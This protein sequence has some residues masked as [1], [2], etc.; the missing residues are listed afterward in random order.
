MSDPPPAFESLV[1]SL[2]I[3]AAVC[4]RMASSFSEAILG[5]AAN[6][7]ASGGPTRA[8]MD[9]W[10]GASTR[11]LMADAVPLR[12]LGALHD[13]ALSGDD[14]ALATAYPSDG[15]SGDAEAAWAAA[16]NATAMSPERLARFMDHEPQTNEVRRSA[17]LLGGFLA[18]AA[19]TRLPIR[20]FEIGASAGLNQLWDRYAYR[21][22]EAGTWG[23]SGSPVEIPTD[24][25]GP[26]PALDAAV[27]VIE[28]AACDRKPVDLRD[29]T[30]RRRLRAYVWADQIDRLERL[31]A[32][33]A[34]ALE[35]GTA[36]D[37]EDAVDW[38]RRRVVVRPGAA[39]VLFHSVFWQY[40]PPESQ[41]ALAALIAEI[42]ATASADAPFAW[43]RMEPP[44]TDM[45][46]MELRLTLWPGG[47]DRRLG[48]VH[49][50]GVWVAW[51]D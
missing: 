32:A 4:G 34:M 13:L 7:V 25:R 51:G 18:I 20:L 29:P 6:D 11:D 38:T 1:Q 24:W 14:A 50:H 35:A 19:E 23:P 46:T 47:E 28:R 44:P 48:T 30:A 45:A 12:L 15:S 41:A 33:V 36:V 40:M 43:L 10:A 22:G 2:Q 49:P 42:G 27:A 21:L 17:C 39:T 31:D 16:L 37:A 5:A 3:Q 8:L 26:L 9:R